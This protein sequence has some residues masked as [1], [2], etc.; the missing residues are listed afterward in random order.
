VLATAL[1]SGCATVPDGAYYP[2]PSARTSHIAHA[3]YRAARSV[4]DDPARYS[5]ALVKSRDISAFSGEEDATFYFS[6][7]LAALPAAHVDALV[8]REVA[9]EV[10][11]H[12][13][14]RRVLSMG[15]TGTFTVLGVIVPGLSVADW[16]VNP[17]IVRAFTRD[18]VIAADL[19]AIEIIRGMGHERPRRALAAALYAAHATNGTSPGG[20]LATVPRLSERIAALEPLEPITDLAQRK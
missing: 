20:V 18:Q 8:A 1:V 2:E 19:R 6:D 17:L 13:G 10:L 5:F 11:G 4:G 3:L 7:G 15:I 9:H 14:H 12:A 16:I